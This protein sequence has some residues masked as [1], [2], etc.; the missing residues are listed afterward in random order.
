VV[1]ERDLGRDRSTANALRGNK[2]P[3]LVDDALDYSAREADL[4]QTIGDDCRAGKASLPVLLA[5]A[6]GDTPQPVFGEQVFGERVIGAPAHQ[7]AGDL[8]ETQRLSAEHATLDA[9]FARP[10]SSGARAAPVT[11][12]PA[13]HRDAMADVLDFSIAQAC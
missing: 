5:H 10:R 13:P 6:A 2:E 12:P 3:V 1:D 7:A 9:T 11:V 8:G 4:G